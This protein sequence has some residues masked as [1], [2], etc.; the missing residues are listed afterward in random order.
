[1]FEARFAPGGFPRTDPAV[2]VELSTVAAASTDVEVRV[3]MCTTFLSPNDA[4]RADTNTNLDGDAVDV[5]RAA[6]R[7]RVRAG[8]S[9]FGCPVG[10]LDLCKVADLGATGLCWRR[11][12]RQQVLQTPPLCP[13]FHAAR[14]FYRIGTFG[15]F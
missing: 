9:Q 8:R 12:E 4:Q 14:S 7:G 10:C 3:C 5:A 1:M 6:V 2:D 11:C 15:L 13:D